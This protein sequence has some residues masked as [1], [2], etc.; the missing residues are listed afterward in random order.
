[1]LKPQGLSKGQSSHPSSSETVCH[2]KLFEEAKLYI[3]NWILSESPMRSLGLLLN[4]YKGAENLDLET[5][6]RLGEVSEVLLSHQWKKD[7][8]AKRTFK[9]L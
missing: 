2:L 5:Q 7:N 6:I 9:D 3:S 8:Q 1:V 4:N